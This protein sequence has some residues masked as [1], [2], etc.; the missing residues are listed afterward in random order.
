MFTGIIEEVGMIH[1]VRDDGHGK[2]LEIHAE[3]VLEGTKIG[4]S[5]ATDGI[6]LT[7]TALT[8]N[9]F[10]VDVMPETVKRST[11]AGMNRGFR[12]NL[13][14]A[15]RLSDRIGGHLVT[16]HIDGT[17]IIKK[18]SRE[19]G[20][21]V[22]SISAGKDL[23]QYMVTK[24]SVAID[25]I[26]L[27]LISVDSDGFSIGMIPHTQEATTLF[28]KRAGDSVNIECDLLAKYVEKLLKPEKAS[29][30][31]TMKKLIEEGYL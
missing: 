7:V 26:S 14:R 24:G 25:G 20:A 29:G 23:L 16:G 30:E 9:G 2:S 19:G 13:E 4:D 21:E 31:V 5:I 6:C 28:E 22:F 12:V 27:T 18:R 1:A 11:V 15:M 17:G 3:K 10:T 8:R